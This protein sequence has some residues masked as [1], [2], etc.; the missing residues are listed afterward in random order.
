M[1]SSKAAKPTQPKQ[2]RCCNRGLKAIQVATASSI[3][4]VLVLWVGLFQF[5][6]PF[7]YNEDNLGTGEHYVSAVEQ[8]T[9]REIHGLESASVNNSIASH[10]TPF[11]SMNATQQATYMDSILAALASDARQILNVK[12][13]ESAVCDSTPDSI[14]LFLNHRYNM[15]LPSASYQSRHPTNAPN[16][17]TGSYFVDHQRYFVA[18]NF[19]NSQK[20]LPTIFRELLKLADFLGPDRIFISIFENGSTDQTKK[21]LQLFQTLLDHLNIPSSIILSD[22]KSDY[23]HMNRIEVLAEYRNRAL[24]PMFTQKLYYNHVIFINDVFHC[25]DDTLE[26]MYQTHVQQADMTCGFDYWIRPDK[27]YDTWVARTLSGNMVREYFYQ[28]SFAYDPASRSRYELGLPISAFSCWNGMTVLNSDPFYKHNVRFRRSDVDQGECSASE[29][30]LLAKDFW[31]NGF[32]KVLMVPQVRVVYDLWL[33]A[34]VRAK[35]F[36]LIQIGQNLGNNPKYMDLDGTANARRKRISL[37]MG[38]NEFGGRSLDLKWWNRMM[39]LGWTHEPAWVAGQVSEE[40]V[41]NYPGPEKVICFGLDGV[42]N[43]NADWE[44][45]VFE[46]VEYKV[47]L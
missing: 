15:L 19:H 38:L 30:Q 26:L 35:R 11:Q 9:F 13:L 18:L 32:G 33:H 28:G 21:L 14:A 36:E 1:N 39:W 12:K 29:C 10:S 27:F 4:L 34:S 6:L 23:E 41:W 5:I 47:G 45:P 3:L 8:L 16:N 42:N 44:N 7:I 40:V 37:K 43:P 24:E 31:T 25:L 2:I 17:S 46:T 20:V 22:E